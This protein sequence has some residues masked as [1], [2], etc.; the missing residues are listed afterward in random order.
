VAVDPLNQSSCNQLVC[1]S[2]QIIHDDVSVCVL[3]MLRDSHNLLKWFQRQLEPYRNLVKVIDLTSSW[4]NGLALC[5]L[6]HLN[7][8]D[9]LYDVLVHLLDLLVDSLIDSLN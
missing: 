5:S 3:D 6:I 9:L 4:R 1:V 8:P 2:Y 7:R